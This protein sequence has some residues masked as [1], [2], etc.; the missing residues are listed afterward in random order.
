MT[1]PKTPKTPK[2]PTAPKGTPAPTVAA[3]TR[4][5]ARAPWWL[6]EATLGQHEAYMGILAGPPRRREGGAATEGGAS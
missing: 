1:A 6:R 3:G 2:T 4:K 5:A